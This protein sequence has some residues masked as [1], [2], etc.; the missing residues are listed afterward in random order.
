[1]LGIDPGSHRTGYGCVD[2]DGTRHRLVLSGTVAVPPGKPLA[3]RLRLI[4]DG[5]ADVVRTTEPDCVAVENLF[6]ARNVR[7]ALT[8]GHA[9]GVAMLAAVRAQV[10]IVEYTP[11]QIKLA[12]AGYGRAEKTQLRHMI[13]LL[14]GLEA[15]P[16][17]LDAS[18]ALAIAICHAQVASSPI[19]AA[20]PSALPRTWRRMKASQIVRRQAPQ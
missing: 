2:S 12:V 6:Y 18:D 14:L 15:G 11:T 17:S 1:V 10:P 16:R 4:H 13:A 20:G 3:E 5:L 9:R 19:T 8:L 7:S